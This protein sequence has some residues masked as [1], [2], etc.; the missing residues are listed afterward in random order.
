MNG[1]LAGETYL[2]TISDE[3]AARFAEQA[4]PKVREFKKL[5]NDIGTQCKKMDAAYMCIRATVDTLRRQKVYLDDP[6]SVITAS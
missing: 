6:A 2:S 4:D 3:Q 1:G 5:F